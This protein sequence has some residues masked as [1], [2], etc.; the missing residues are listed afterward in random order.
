MQGSTTTVQYD[1]VNTNPLS[2]MKDLPH[3]GFRW[4]LAQFVPPTS[5]GLLVACSIFILN[6]RAQ[7]PI[8]IRTLSFPIPRS[9]GTLSTPKETS[10][11]NASDP[12][13]PAVGTL[14]LRVAKGHCVKLALNSEAFQHPEN[15]DKAPT[16]GI[17]V[18]E[19]HLFAMDEDEEKLCNV[20]IAKCG[21]FKNLRAL[22]VDKSAA[23]DAAIAKITSMP[24]VTYLSASLSEITGRCFRNFGKQ[25][26][27]LR[28]LLMFDNQ[29]DNASLQYLAD[30]K[31]LELIDMRRDNLNNTG[32][33]H[34]CKCANLTDLYISSNG[35]VN[36]GCLK[37]LLYLK[38]LRCL[39]ISDTAVTL[40]GLKT[41][42]PLHLN[43]MTVSAETFAPKDLPEL[44]KIA[45]SVGLIPRAHVTKT[46]EHMF[47]PLNLH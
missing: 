42:T 22:L 13:G 21:H 46:D 34:L 7:E 19:P 18:L 47:A 31:D 36:D 20:V 2:R 33:K 27:K 6:V 8:E 10:L 28:S 44:Q 35:L 15:I 17:D 30:C 9:M 39:Y 12:V 14:T 25:F 11:D 29:V 3:C 26:P 37:D 23:S 24:K 4:Q 16:T 40:N 43:R 5:C 45:K 32:I 38:K 1:L 41:L